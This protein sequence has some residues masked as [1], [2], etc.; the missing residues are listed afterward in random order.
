M[1]NPYVIENEIRY[2][3]NELE[4]ELKIQRI[5]KQ[6]KEKRKIAQSPKSYFKLFSFLK[7]F[8]KAW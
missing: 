4:E 3:K 8:V 7:A 1:I 6:L 2:R 5:N